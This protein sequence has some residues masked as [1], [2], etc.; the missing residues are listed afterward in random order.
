MPGSPQKSL[1]TNNLIIVKKSNAE[2]IAIGSVQRRFTPAKGL[3][4]SRR[5]KAA[6]DRVSHSTASE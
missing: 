4:I 3:R 1:K 5:R 6:C 2:T